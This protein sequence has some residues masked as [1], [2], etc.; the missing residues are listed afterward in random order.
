MVWQHCPY[1]VTDTVG[2]R[3]LG[4]STTAT[5]LVVTGS[6]HDLPPVMTAGCQILTIQAHS[7]ACPSS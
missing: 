3:R 5:L 1:T 2:G 6:R 7:V 4:F